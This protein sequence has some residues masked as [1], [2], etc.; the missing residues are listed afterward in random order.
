MVSQPLGSWQLAWDRFRRDRV[1]LAS[2][3]F[4]VVLLIA[5]FGGEPLAERLLGHGPN[6]LFPMGADVDKNLLPAG[7]WTHVPNTH[8]VIVVTPKTPTTLF[9]LGSSDTLGHDMFLRLLAGGRTTLEIGLGASA[10]A[11]GL[12]LL[13][14]L[15][16]GYFGGWPDAAASRITELIMGFPVLFFL[17]AIGWSVSQRL[18]TITLDGAFTR[19]VISLVLVVGVFYCF[20]PARLVRAQVLSLREQ[21]FVEAARMIGASDLRIMR[22]HLLPY[23]SGSLIV[24]ATQLIA[25]TIFLEAA[26][27]ILG[28][29]IGL[30]DASWGNLISANYGTLLAP[31][32]PN[33]YQE[34]SFLRTTYLTTLWP[35]LLV[36]LTVVAFTLCGEG[37]RNA[38]DPRAA[39]R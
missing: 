22:K 27:S 2:G 13:L 17:I 21:E 12:G 4:I 39:R 24:Y 31:G 11:V 14:G 7:P 6:D 20:Y 38:V 9:I 10:L 18:N 30:P 28:V 25:I 33:S 8:S 35:S 16:S 32:G 34:T 5:C 26:L 29:G 15:L 3:I 1:A 37:I 36:F 23:V 19:G